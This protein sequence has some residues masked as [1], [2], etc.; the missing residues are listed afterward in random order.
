MN[1][2]VE[3]L[4]LTLGPEAPFNQYENDDGAVEDTSSEEGSG[5]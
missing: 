4:T 3:M 5:Y 2:N 1:Q